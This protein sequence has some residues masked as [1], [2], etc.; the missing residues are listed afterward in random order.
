MADPNS[1]IPEIISQTASYPSRQLQVIAATATTVTAAAVGEDKVTETTTT[2][3]DIENLL[4]PR[5]AEQGQ[6][7]AAS[8]PT[9][10]RGKHPK[11]RGVRSRSGKWVSEIREPRKTTRIWLGTYPTPEMAA[12]AYDVAALALRSAEAVLNFPAYA[13]RYPVPVSS[14]AADI[15]RAA[16]SAAAMMKPESSSGDGGGSRQERK[17]DPSVNTEYI[18][19]EELF[20]MHNLLV[21]MAG[22]M[23][24][25]PPRINSSHPADD[26]P[27]NSDAETL[28][29]Y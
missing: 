21:D 19:E 12:A 17:D 23:M 5:L 11:Y 15:R 13:A 3:L 9:G 16:A 27:E 26:S 28:W 25:S 18:D 6:A 4:S 2:T 10:G 20:D 7:A 22:G 1:K 29:N 14:E 24:V 8:S